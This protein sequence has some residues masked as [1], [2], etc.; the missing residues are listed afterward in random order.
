MKK[1]REELYPRDSNVVSFKVD[2]H[3]IYDDDEFEIDLATVEC[4]KPKPNDEKN[5][6]DSGKLCQESKDSLDTIWDLLKYI[7]WGVKSWSLQISGSVDIDSTTHYTQN[8][9]YVVIPRFQ[10]HFPTSFAS[11]ADFIDDINNLLMI[12]NDIEKTAHYLQHTL[13]SNW[14]SVSSIS[15]KFEYAIN[16]ESPPHL[17]STHIN[18]YYTPPRNDAT[19]SKA[20][21]FVEMSDSLVDMTDIEGF[22]SDTSNLD[23]EEGEEEEE[24]RDGFKKQADGSWLHIAAGVHMSCNPFE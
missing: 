14:N 3:F 19:R 5:E 17:P 8:G 23:P 20:P 9:F 4:S 18:T 10:F 7:Q 12:R 13:K 22:D 15:Q 2:L 6:C 1:G 16:M 24:E 11:M 21:L